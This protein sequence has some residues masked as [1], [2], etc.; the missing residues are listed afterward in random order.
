MP[1]R[2]RPPP[3]AYSVHVPLSWQDVKVGNPL[4]YGTLPDDL[5]LAR[6][7]PLEA[8]A[9]IDDLRAANFHEAV[10]DDDQRDTNREPR[11]AAAPTPNTKRI[12]VLISHGMGQQLPFETLHAVAEGIWSRHTS[13][14]MRVDDLRVRYVTFGSTWRPRVELTLS[15][16]APDS[17]EQ[18]TIT[19]DVHLYEAYWAPLTEGEARIHEVFAFLLGAAKRG[20]QYGLKGFGRYMFG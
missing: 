5:T 6:E 12:A 8:A 10:P 1:Q 15:D 13:A 17:D 4:S 2:R 16:A 14:N 19:R 9:L 20:V 3:T 7:E 11:Y 18:A